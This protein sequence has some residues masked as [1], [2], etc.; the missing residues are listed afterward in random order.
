MNEF[1]SGD[2]VILNT[3]D[4]NGGEKVKIYGAGAAGQKVHIFKKVNG[5]TATITDV[6]SWKAMLILDTPIRIRD[7]VVD[8]VWIE[9]SWPYK[10]TSQ[11]LTL[12]QRCEKKFE[13][14]D[15]VILNDFGN[16]RNSA[17]ADLAGVSLENEFK[18]VAIDDNGALTVRGR[19]LRSGATR[20]YGYQCPLYFD[21]TEEV[22]L[23]DILNN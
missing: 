10:L 16:K 12:V 15:H 8:T 14:G 4:E 20:T 5:L 13:I 6:Y 21:K 18:I 17:L 11:F 1:K 19:T 7:R 9:F 22:S 2:R 23:L 3:M